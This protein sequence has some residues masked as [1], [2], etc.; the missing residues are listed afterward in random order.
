MPTHDDTSKPA[1]PATDA[2]L[3]V[4]AGQK[5]KAARLLMD[6]YTGR[7]ASMFRRNSL[8]DMTEE[9]IS[10]TFFKFLNLKSPLKA[11]ECAEAYLYRTARN[12]LVDYA[13]KR[14]ALTRGGGSKDG[15]AEVLMDDEELLEAMA[16]D[17]EP[18]EDPLWH[19][20]LTDCVEKALAHMRK[21]MP[22]TAEAL[23]LKYR[24]YTNEEVAI[25]YGADLDGLT[26]QELQ[27][28]LAN[29]RQRLSDACLKARPYFEHCKD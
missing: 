25:Y 11:A 20:A 13:R 15:S 8:R 22:K 24:D 26:P 18:S 27:R 9:M 4:A 1:S 14:G 19:K 17:A 7:F 23:W 21:E 6:H 3:M 12:V 10:D 2:L 16:E 5:D 28:V 29:A